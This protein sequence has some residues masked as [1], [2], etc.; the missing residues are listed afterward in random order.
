MTSIQKTKIMTMTMTILKICVSDYIS[1][2][3]GM[4]VLNLDFKIYTGSKGHRPNLVKG[5]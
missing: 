3:H 2:M 5:R 1:I 4:Q